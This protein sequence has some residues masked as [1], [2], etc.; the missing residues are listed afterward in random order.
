[1]VDESEIIILL[2][3]VGVYAGKKKGFWEEEN[4][5]QEEEA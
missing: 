1:M 5:K 3:H 4:E 2:R